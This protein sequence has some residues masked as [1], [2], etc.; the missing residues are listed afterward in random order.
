MKRLSHEDCNC[1]KEKE[2]EL[3]DYWVSDEDLIEEAYWAKYDLDE[4][5]G[6]GN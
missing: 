4:A 3:C 6:K 5:E 2:C 1:D